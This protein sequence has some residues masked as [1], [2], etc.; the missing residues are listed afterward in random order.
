M[1]CGESGVVDVRQWGKDKGLSSAYPV[2]CHLMDAAATAGVLWEIWFGKGELVQWKGLVSFWAGLHDIGKVSPSFQVKVTELFRKMVDESPEYGA[3][4]AVPSLGHHEVT[5][6][7]LVQILRDFGYKS[8]SSALRDVGHQVAQ[9]LGGHHGRFCAPV[10]QGKDW[11][12]P[13]G[14]TGVGAGRWEEERRRHAELL[15][16]LTGA[17]EGLDEHLPPSLVVLA[18]GVIVV[19]DWLVSQT[20]FIEPRLPGKGWR[21]T[22]EEVQAHWERALADAPQLIAEAGLGAAEFL[23]LPFSSLFGFEPNKLQLSL[24]ERLPAMV[25]GAGMLLVTAPPGDGKTEAALYSAGILGRA[26]RATGL[27]FCL[28]TMATTDAMH[29]RVQT[30]LQKAFAGSPALTK[31]HSMAWL[32]RDGAA[33][34]AASA[35]EAPAVV[36]DRE[37]SEEATKWLHTG[38]RGLLAPLSTLTIDQALAGVL[39]L[40][41]NVLRL[42]AL[43]GKVLVI[44]EAHSFDAWMHALLL[45]FLEWMGAMGA[46]VVVLSATLTGETARSLVAAYLRGCGHDLAD[47][48]APVYP[49]W[50]FVSAASGKVSEPVSVTSERE[51]EIEF[52]VRAVRRGDDT[53]HPEHRISVIKDLLRPLTDGP[54]GCAL[55]C[56]TTV[57][58][59]QETYAAL[60]TW[61]S[62][63]RAAG[64]EVPELRLLHSRF[65][66]KDRAA[67]TD[68]CER[69]F[70][71][72]GS[73]PSTVLVA[74]QIVEQSLDLDFDLII[75][76][77]APLAFLLQRSGRCRRHQNPSGDPHQALRPS[78]LSPNPRVVVLDPVDGKGGFEV[79]EKWGD[80][81][82]HALLERTSILLRERS[83]GPVGIPSDVQHLVDEV[84]SADFSAAHELLEEAARRLARKD[85]E[86][87]AANAAQAQLAGK[88]V[89]IPQPSPRKLRDL[90]VLTTPLDG[91]DE[92]LIATRLGAD[93]A[94]LVC[95]YEQDSGIWTLDEDGAIPV[96]GLNGV[97]NVSREDARTVAHHMLPVPARWTE[98][99]ADLMASP[100]AWEANSVLCSWKLLPMRRVDAGEWAG[101]LQPGVVRYRTEIGIAPL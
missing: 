24:V 12:E 91:V 49:G 78:W 25:D 4:E 41:F 90:S 56:C 34:A 62:E 48:F 55:V 59:A 95:V 20:T 1:S 87:L 44:D 29:R 72:K 66:A 76:D 43:S 85:G 82:S 40:K 79:P 46:P 21:A 42:M 37:A 101:R 5:H 81:Y 19:A 89:A 36:S 35:A 45:R 86:Q 6:W 51:R 70:G 88:L 7:S 11:K 67:I 53:T 23:D 96:P 60:A 50:L 58:E 65:R 32:S 84:Y 100:T 61:F 73:R 93:S 92:N 10:P 77:L 57:G 28:P 74:T 31:V 99:G 83:D 33:D 97:G 68:A 52:P 15:R 38:K 27:G 30:Y 94:R 9:M 54:Q 3:E 98:G 63:L 8:G 22:E 14:R 13:L 2:V 16:R 64:Q 47:D 80:V 18:L 17:E 69:D 71:K 39:P 26:S 75:S